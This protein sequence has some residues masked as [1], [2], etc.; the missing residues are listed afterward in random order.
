MKNYDD[1]DRPDDK[2]GVA[3]QEPKDGLSDAPNAPI[4]SRRYEWQDANLKA[5]KD[6]F[7]DVTD[8][9]ILGR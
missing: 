6:I 8:E 2:T 9:H 3:T 5:P 1:K 4:A 7:G